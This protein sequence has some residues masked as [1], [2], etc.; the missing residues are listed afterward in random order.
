MIPMKL[1]GRRWAAPTDSFIWRRAPLIRGTDQIGTS[2]NRSPSCSGKTAMAR[3][4][5]A[6]LQAPHIELD[7][8]HWL[9]GWQE[10]DDAE[11]RELTQAAVA[12]DRWVVDSSYNVLRDIV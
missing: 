1:F 12:A 4:V 7:A 5:A 11:F 6:I 8:I 10:R 2:S 9:T 3:R